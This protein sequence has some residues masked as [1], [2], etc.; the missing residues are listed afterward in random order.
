MTQDGAA[1]DGAAGGGAG[2][3]VDGHGIEPLGPATWPAFADLAERHNGVWGGCWCTWFHL[4]PDPPER[5]EC[6]NREF[7]R[8]LVEAGRTHAALVMDGDEAIAWAQF[9][10]VGE[11]R[12][13]HHRKQWEA[14]S[15]REPDF[16]ITCLFVDRRFRRQGMAGIAV[17][18]ALALIAAA[19]GGLVEAYPHDL[20]P[21]RKVSS[22]F[23]YNATRTMYEGLGFTYERPKGKGNCV[24]TLTLPVLDPTR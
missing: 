6:G 20:E 10:T 9:G 12:N 17:R 16:R 2:I 4:Y 3:V 5:R 14:E 8:R 7:K 24:M 13:I 23:L 22:S 1:Q 11:L 21:G 15:V 18:G 19:G